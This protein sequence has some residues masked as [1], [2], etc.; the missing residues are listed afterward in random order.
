MEIL[1]VE[2]D[3]RISGFLV[4]GLK[5]N[6]FSVTLAESAEEA[7]DLVGAK[8]WNIILLDIMLPGIDGLEFTK[9]IRFKK[10]DT[11]IL[12]LSA[13]SGV[14]D[15]V[16][17]L[18][19]GADDYLVKPFH[20]DELLSRI[21]ALIRR[22][23]QKYSEQPN[24]L[25]FS[26]LTVNKDEYSVSTNGEKKELSPKE[27]KLLL[28]LMENQN[29]VLSRTQI[30]NSVWGIDYENNTNVVDVYISYLR[31][32]IENP[33]RKIIHTVKGIGYMLKDES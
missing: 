11:P 15:K 27:Y 10:N 22:H 9:L 33:N 24:L 1:L 26:Y 21:N 7:R 29:K 17:A 32:K 19:I 5:E 28:L 2:D 18:D 4:K 14:D 13:L 16:K 3:Q 30:L 20:F 25:E 31:S 12:I 8:S 6:Q 23:Q